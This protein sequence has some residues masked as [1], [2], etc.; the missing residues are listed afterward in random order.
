MLSISLLHTPL[1]ASLAPSHWPSPNASAKPLPR[2]VGHPALEASSNQSQLSEVLGRPRTSV[3]QRTSVKMLRKQVGRSVGSERTQ[4]CLI[5]ARL[6]LP[7]PLPL[8]LGFLGLYSLQHHRPH[9]YPF[10]PQIQILQGS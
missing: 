7:C 9:A 5:H 2:Q 1:L 3:W 10:N 8:F 4:S 6:S